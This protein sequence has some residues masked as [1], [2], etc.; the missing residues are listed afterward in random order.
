M[1]P[2]MWFGGESQQGRGGWLL[3]VDWLLP[4]MVGFG[5]ER[6]LGHGDV[7]HLH[8]AA[9]PVWSRRSSARLPVIAR[10]G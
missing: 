2:R 1:R 5:P 6:G 3:G 9:G 10:F 7:R 8:E 4:W